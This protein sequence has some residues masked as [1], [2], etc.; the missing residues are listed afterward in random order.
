M[1]IIGIF[2]VTT[3]QNR[4][5]AGD[6]LFKKPPKESQN[7]EVGLGA[8]GRASQLRIFNADF[9]SCSSQATRLGSRCHF[10]DGRPPLSSGLAFASASRL[11]SR[12]MARYLLVVLTLTC[13]SQWAMV[14]NQR[15][16]AIDGRPC[17]GV[18][19]LRD[20]GATIYPSRLCARRVAP[21]L[22]E[23]MVKV[24]YASGCANWW[25]LF[26]IRPQNTLLAEHLHH[27]P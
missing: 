17:C 3:L 2:Q 16:N 7:A 23:V 25:L 5:F 14:L 11:A 15:L 9:Q 27:L 6:W 1:T 24:C 10:P 22:I 13:P 12:S 20:I 18:Y 19:V 26:G 8:C 4:G 21:H